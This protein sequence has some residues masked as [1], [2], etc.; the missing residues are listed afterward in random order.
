MS[1]FDPFRTEDSFYSDDVQLNGFT[2]MEQ[3]S[4]N[5]KFVN[6]SGITR[7]GFYVPLD[8]TIQTSGNN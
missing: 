7:I 2:Y 1:V 4:G 6:G 3:A 8:G 5:S